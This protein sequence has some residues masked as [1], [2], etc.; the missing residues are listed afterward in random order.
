M[1][2]MSRT[3]GLVLLGGAALSACCCLLPRRDPP[4]PPQQYDE[5]GNPIPPAQTTA[6]STVRRHGPLWVPWYWGGSSYSPGYRPGTPFR[7]GG[8]TYRSGPTFRPG[9]ASPV[10]PGGTVT[11]GGFGSTGRSVGGSAA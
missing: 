7:S 5:N 9:G 2:R 4:P 3:I 10:S 11:R 6:H 8:T 1:T